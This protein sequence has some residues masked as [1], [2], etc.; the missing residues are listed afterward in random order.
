MTKMK[1]KI[2]R[3]FAA[4][5]FCGAIATVFTACS[6]D[7][8]E[9]GNTPT[10]EPTTT[11]QKAER[12][13]V[14]YH[15]VLADD[16]LELFDVVVNNESSLSGKSTKTL[17]KTWLVGETTEYI[18]SPLKY[19]FSVTVTPKT[20]ITIDATKEYSL[21]LA[22]ELVFLIQDAKKAP[23]AASGSQPNVVV[24]KLSG[25]K[26][27]EA[28]MKQIADTFSGENTLEI[29]TDYYVIN[30]NKMNY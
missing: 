17:S 18:I 9:P 1:K 13:E 21:G 20:G 11:V 26:L 6:K 14:K 25:D 16:M 15:V 28:K 23:L 10:P 29:S 7:D 2:F 3:M 24:T 4:I 22:A 8:D 5:L 27:T 19:A 30:G 12:A